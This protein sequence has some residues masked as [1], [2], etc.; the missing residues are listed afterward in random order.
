[1]GGPGRRWVVP[2]VVFA[3][4]VI[5]FANTIDRYLVWSDIFQ[6]QRAH[7]LATG[8][9]DLQKIWSPDQLRENNYFRPLQ[10]V[11]LSLDRWL[12]GERYEG[13]HLTQVVLHALLAVALFLI[14][15]RVVRALALPHA[16]V[17][18][19][20]A[21]IGWAIAP[22]R[23]ESVA[24]LAD[25]GSV[26]QALTVFGLYLG[27]RLAKPTRAAVVA[28]ALVLLGLLSKEIAVTAPLLFALIVWIERR[29]DRRLVL[30]SLAIAAVT[31]LILRRT[32]FWSTLSFD[33]HYDLLTR[34]RTQVAVTADYLADTMS[35]L[36]PSASDVVA[37]RDRFDARVVVDL[38]LL[39]ALLGA[40]V[41][42]ARKDD[43]LP[44]FALLWFFVALAPAANL[45]VQ[46]HFRGDR[47]VYLAAFGP[48]LL[49]T[50]RLGALAAAIGQR[51]RE[52]LVA[53]GVAAAALVV[54][55]WATTVRNTEWST[56]EPTSADASDAFF[57]IELSR[58]PRFREAIGH[59]CMAAAQRGDFWKS[60]ELCARGL[61]IDE[62]QWTSTAWQPKAF[63]AALFD[64]EWAQHDKS[65]CARLL[66]RAS[67]GR[68][69]WPADENIAERARAVERRCHP[70]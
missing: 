15:E 16:R 3:S 8:R 51:F 19:A 67:D 70:P 45:G 46:R 11:S 56:H 22:Q 55:G 33:V 50:V 53:P 13:F 66:S 48:V 1:M 60:R 43:R 65:S 23:T 52:R 32:V 61:A 68:A 5:T 28:T 59:L 25:R 34:L 40:G 38:A 24:W 47:Y 6:I 18:A 41:H 27:L 37:V 10:V 7:M 12:F 63:W 4:V 26:L 31:Y 2:L 54:L 39:L 14:A 42:R 17:V 49:L 21:A 58:A 29:D 44:L 64:I 57:R 36:H 35:P 69:R 30:T 20:V 9:H 62:K